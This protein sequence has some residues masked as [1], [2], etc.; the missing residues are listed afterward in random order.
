M[1]PETTPDRNS[2]AL[3]IANASPRSI[4]LIISI[5][6]QQLTMMK[7]N[8]VVKSYAIS[9]GLA[10]A[11]EEVD[12]GKTPRGIHFIAEKLGADAPIGLVFEDLLPTEKIADE[13]WLGKPPVTTRVLRLAGGERKNLNTFDRLIYIHGSPIIRLLRQPASGGCIRLTALNVI[14][15]FDNVQVGTRVLI[16]EE[17][18]EDTILASRVHRAKYEATTA[19]ALTGDSNAAHALCYEHR[20]GVNGQEVSNEHASVWCLEGSQLGNALSMTVLAELLSLGLAGTRDVNMALAWYLKAARLGQPFAKK[21]AIEY[22]T[23][24]V[25]GG[26]DEERAQ[27]LRELA[28][29][30]P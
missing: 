8:S 26:N 16:S 28:T 12:S 25:A 14:E 17:S 23:E 22:L 29:V 10:G 30:R 6:D 27:T 24:G 7:G 2:N 5:A 18:L 1:L 13:S 3:K 15:L 11:G 9:T 4:E 21:K 19:A 20:Y